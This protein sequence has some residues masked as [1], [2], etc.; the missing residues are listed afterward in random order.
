MEILTET[1]LRGKCPCGNCD[2][3]YEPGTFLTESARSYAAERG[4]RLLERGWE[5][6]RWTQP[7]T[8]VPG[9]RKP[10][11]MTQLRAGELVGKRDP[12][13]RFRGRMDS[14]QAELLCAIVSSGGNGKQDL[15]AN[16]GEVLSL[17]RNILGSEVKQ[18]PLPEWTL[19]GMTPEEIHRQSH[20]PPHAVPE[21]R[22]GETAVGLNRLRALS[23][24]LELCWLDAY[25]DGQQPE[26][27][28][29]LNRISS[30][31]YVLYQREVTRHE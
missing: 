22:M 31:I 23:C 26:I 16:L 17:C 25:S 21:A 2:F 27:L 13:I 8:P 14:F 3:R 12:R 1:I 28:L 6:M 19:F 30:A 10:E 11:A 20:V 24:E 9:E 4:I 15:T 7:P 18:T 29:A 5:E